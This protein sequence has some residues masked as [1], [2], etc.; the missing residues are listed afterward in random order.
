[1]IYKIAHISDLHIDR[2]N[3]NLT[4]RFDRLLK[5]ISKKKV[6]HLF[7][8]GDI[9]H[10]PDEANFETVIKKLKKYGY[11]RREKL[12]V[13]IGNHEVF[14]GAEHGGKSY[15][16]PTQC[17]NTDIQNRTKE[18]CNYFGD[19]FPK[20]MKS[21]P[22]A[23][24]IENLVIFGINSVAKW[25]LDGNPIG[26][27][28]EITDKE[29]LILKKLLNSRKYS[30]KLKIA[31]IHHHFYYTSLY[32][33]DEIF[34]N[35]LY[36]ERVTMQLHNRKNII[37]LFRECGIKFVFHGHTH[38]NETYKRDGINFINCSGC[39]LPFSKKRDYEYGIINCL[40]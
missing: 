1:M 25:S 27:N 6:D 7:I 4:E 3:K 24:E 23:K 16:F 9:V 8:T 36:S 31:L 37:N 12:S 5:N 35:W 19:T 14:G 29:I 33:E 17:K 40:I 15:R 34:S 2:Q 30:G 22:Y 39:L 20:E 28:G 26:S 21:F 10:K 18:F 13:C 38:I 11:F 32:K